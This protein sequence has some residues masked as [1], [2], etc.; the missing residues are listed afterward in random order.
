MKEIL[1][2]FLCSVSMVICAQGC[3]VHPVY[4]TEYKTKSSVDII[5]TD[6]KYSADI[7]LNVVSDANRCM[8]NS[9][10]FTDRAWEACVELHPVKHGTGISKVYLF[11]IMEMNMRQLPKQRV[12]EFYEFLNL[13]KK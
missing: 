5:Y 13:H 9:I 1:S 8:D 6:D 12:R 3:I 2:V 7:W 10:I 4:V 11:G